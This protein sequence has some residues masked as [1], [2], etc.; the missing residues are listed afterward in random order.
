LLEKAVAADPNFASAWVELSRA[1]ELSS[2]NEG[3]TT[4][5]R[6]PSEQAFALSERAA[7]RAV[8]AA[9]NYGAAHAALGRALI[10]QGKDQYSDE[11]ERAIVLSPDDPEV[12]REY[13]RYLSEKDTRRALKIFEPLLAREPRDPRL[14]VAYAGLLDSNGDIDEALAQYR[15]AISLDPEYVLPYYRAAGTVHQ[16]V[17]RK[18]LAMRLARR[19]TNLDPDNPDLMYEIAGI[20]WSW[21][22]TELFHEAQQALRR[23]GA[24]RELQRLEADIAVATSHT[25]D[26]RS[27]IKEL[28][29]DG[30]DE[31]A[32]VA[33]TRLRGRAEDYEVALLR[34][35]TFLAGHAWARENGGGADAKLPRY[36]SLPF[37]LREELGGLL[38]HVRMIHQSCH[39]SSP[40]YA[41]PV[42]TNPPLKAGINRYV[43]GKRGRY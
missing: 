16:M 27:A 21:G 2:R 38:F 15:E 32:L 11:F 26:A 34:V 37:S 20:Y 7:R 19:A 4:I 24:K 8:S 18:D 9:P 39:L 23:M 10:I 25:E 13:A 17:G 33:L 31:Y 6:T 43:D 14:R 40:L 30:P 1:Y 42:D 29:A 41:L 36:I 12:I 35:E 22:E 5:G 3:G 28:L